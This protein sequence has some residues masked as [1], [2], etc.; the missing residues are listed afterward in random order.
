MSLLSA[1]IYKHANSCKAKSC[2]ITLAKLAKA[3]SEFSA[4]VDSGAAWAID[5]CLDGLCPNTPSVKPV[6]GKTIRGLFGRVLCALRLEN[7]LL[8]AF[9]SDGEAHQLL[10][11]WAA[12]SHALVP[13][14]DTSIV[15]VAA[16]LVHLGLLSEDSPLAQLV[17]PEPMS[18]EL[19]SVSNSLSF[20]IYLTLDQDRPLQDGDREQIKVCA[21]IS[22]FFFASLLLAP[23]FS[24]SLCLS[25][26]ISN[27]QSR[28][29]MVKISSLPMR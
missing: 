3:Q 4:V 18:P 7:E 16:D 6:T 8:E 13:Q 26:S 29:S 15:M 1:A 5:S 28:Y 23:P 9:G 27:T 19:P 14:K 12:H 21:C 25:P 20:F 2:G 10:F 11:R 22:M 17:A 24:L